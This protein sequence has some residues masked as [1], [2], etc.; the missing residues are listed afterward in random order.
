[1]VGNCN[2]YIN[3]GMFLITQLIYDFIFKPPHPIRCQYPIISYL[4]LA[5]VLYG[6]RSVIVRDLVKRIE[7]TH[8]NVYIRI[9]NAFL[10]NDYYNYVMA[11]TVF[12]STL[13]FTKFIAFHKDFMQITASLKL[14]FQGLATFFV[15]FAIT[16]FAFSAFFFFSLRTDLEKFRDVIHSM[17]FTLAMSIGKFNFANLR[18][19][20]SMAAWIFFVFS[21]KLF[22]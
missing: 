17:E 4:V 18:Q 3:K 14:S 22:L 10:I 7:E 12:T 2:K 20:N 19:A 13:K 16:F 1:M 8:G 21:S 15:E 5:L 6:F 9:T 11:F